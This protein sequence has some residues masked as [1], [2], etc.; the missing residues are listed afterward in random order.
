MQF[1][2]KV[3]KLERVRILMTPIISC[4]LQAK[5]LPIIRLIQVMTLRR[6]PNRIYL[7]SRSEKHLLMR[8]RA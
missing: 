7:I 1:Q 3:I 5:I 6:A 2:A 8:I 4:K